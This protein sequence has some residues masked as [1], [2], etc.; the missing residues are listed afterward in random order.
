MKRIIRLLSLLIL[1]TG[2]L[3][4][5]DQYLWLR[6][7]A[8]RVVT[9]SK[10]RAVQGDTLIILWG[11]TVTPLPLSEVVQIR[12]MSGSSIFEGAMIGA[13]SGL[14]AG[15]LTG[16]TLQAMGKSGPSPATTMIAMGVI[17]AIVGATVSAIEKPGDLVDLS[18]KTV[19]EKRDI[20]RGIV[21]QKMLEERHDDERKR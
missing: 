14:A 17:G 9:N 4:G 1:M 8:D 3:S 15:G 20:I 10:F 7:S 13:G 19:E 16:F 21:L 2:F 5:Q 12:V 18:G 11:G 6:L